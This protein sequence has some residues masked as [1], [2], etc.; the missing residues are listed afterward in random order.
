[1]TKTVA[2]VD[3]SKFMLN[4][5]AKFFTET[6]QFTVIGASTNGMEAIGLYREFKPDLL[7]LDIS[8]PILDGLEV[9]K[10]IIG[11]FPDAKILIVSATR[12][13]I[14]FDCEQAGAADFI[15]KPLLFHDPAFVKRF[16][17]IVCRIVP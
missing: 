17:D 2:I 11:E 15:A 10:E 5:L 3:D 4:A 9:V 8:M 14:L 6:M 13:Q 12:G 7:T 16:R 1:M